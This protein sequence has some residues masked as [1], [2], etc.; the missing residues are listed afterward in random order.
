MHTCISFYIIVD[1]P[2]SCVLRLFSFNGEL[3]GKKNVNWN[4]S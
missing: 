3:S 4:D 2:P 1:G